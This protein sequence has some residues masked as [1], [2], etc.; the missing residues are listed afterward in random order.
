M[1]SICEQGKELDNLKLLE[2]KILDKVAEN[3]EIAR[4]KNWGGFYIKPLRIEFMEFKKTR[5]HDRKLYEFENDMWKMKQ[6]Q[7]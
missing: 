7:P 2:A 5:F 6:I 4:P 1:S 3:E